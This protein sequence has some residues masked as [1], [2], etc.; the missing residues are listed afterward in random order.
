MPY[1]FNLLSRCP[2]LHLPSGIASNGAPTGIQLVA[3]TYED[4][5][6]FQA[7]AAYEQAQGGFI[8]ASNFP[9]YL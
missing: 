2:V 7:A 1:P 9:K 4:A 6:V 3:P 5:V 8:N